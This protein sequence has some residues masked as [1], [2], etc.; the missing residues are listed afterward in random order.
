LSTSIAPRPTASTIASARATGKL[1]VAG[2]STSAAAATAGTSAL[3]AK[4]R[5]NND[6]RA[7][8]GRRDRPLTASG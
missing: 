7:S 4:T 1:T 2:E 8:V 3:V 5:Q 6:T